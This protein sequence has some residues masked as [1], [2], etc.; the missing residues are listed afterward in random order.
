M[1]SNIKMGSDGLPNKYGNF[2]LTD[3]TGTIYIYGLLTA[4]G[5]AQKFNT[6]DVEAKDTLTLKGSY[7]EHN[8]NPQVKNAIFV[9]V[10]KYVDPTTAI[11]AVRANKQAT[12]VIREGQVI[13]IR[14]EKEYD[15]VGR[16]LK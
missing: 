7:S 12:K 4:D 2:D 3:E 13:I 6:L 16:Q 1:V 5:Q 9:S 10:K 8:G 14:E 15:V 11:D